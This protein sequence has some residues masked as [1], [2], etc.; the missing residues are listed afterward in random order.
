MEYTPTVLRELL[1]QP[2][3]IYLLFL[4][5]SAMQI[6][7]PPAGW[8]G[9]VGN[10]ASFPPTAALQ[11]AVYAQVLLVLGLLVN[12]WGWLTSLR[13]AVTVAIAGWIVELVGSRTGIPFGRYSYTTV[14]KPQ[15]AGVPLTVPLAW[16]MMLPPA[17]A[18]GAIIGGNRWSAILISAGAITAWD[19]FLDPLMVGWNCW[20]WKRPGRYLG[21]PLVNFLGWFLAAVVITFIAAPPEL[22][23]LLLPLLAIYLLTWLLQ[24]IAQLF[25]WKKAKSAL[26]GFVAMGFF[27]LVALWRI[28]GPGGRL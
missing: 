12:S 16:L 8:R 5:W 7:V 27:V 26:G 28:V 18:V 13:V 11:W 10:N 22:S 21:I 9:G 23:G 25:F 1:Q 3:I 4:V 17:W 14:L 19:F 6:A 15:I 20:R 2:V 24:T